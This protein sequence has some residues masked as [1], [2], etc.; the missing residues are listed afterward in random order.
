MVEKSQKNYKPVKDAASENRCKEFHGH[1]GFIAGDEARQ[2]LPECIYL[3]S[4]PQVRT[5]YPLS[6]CLY[7][8]VLCDMFEDSLM[9]CYWLLMLR[10]MPPLAKKYVL[11]LLFIDVSVTGKMLEEWVLGDGLSKHKVAIDRLI[12]LRVLTE[13]L[14]R[15]F[16][17]L[18][19]YCA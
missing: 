2:A 11:Q 8:W 15:Y 12:Q 16:I 4:Y 7:F 9:Y 14:D 18:S 5:V 17:L 10:S 3:R 13:T 6:E 19:I 1:G